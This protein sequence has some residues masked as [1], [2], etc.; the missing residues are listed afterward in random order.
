MRTAFSAA[1]L[2]LLIAAWGLTAPQPAAD[3]SVR[4]T[5]LDAATN[6]PVAGVIRVRNAAGESLSLDA[7]LPRGRG[8]PEK[9]AIHDWHVFTE[10]TV[11]RLPR[12]QFTITAFSGLETEIAA[13]PLDLRNRDRADVTLRLR[14][15]HDAHAA[16][17]WNAN[18]HVHLQKLD[19]GESDRYLVDIGMADGLDLVFVSYLERAEADVDYI[20][21]KYSRA[22]L[23]A[24][25]NAHVHFDHGEEHRHNFTGYEEGYGHVMLLAIPELIYPVSIGPGISKTGTDG[26]PLKRGIERARELGGTV[27]WCHNQ[28]GLE[29][30]PNWLAG[31]LHANNIFDGGSHGSFEH[32]F[33]RYLNAGLKVPFST[34]TDWF[35]YDFSRVYVPSRERPSPEEWLAQ[36]AAG[37]SYITNGPLL[38]FTVE[39]R[40]IGEDVALERP[41]KV[42]V[43]GSAI[44][45]VDFRKIEILQDGAVIHTGASQPVGAAWSAEL[46]VDVDVTRP[47][48]LALRTPPPS[49]PDD[50]RFSNKAP[51]NEYGRE[52]FAHTSAT[53]VDVA[54]K[55]LFDR[56]AA[57][58]L[59]AEMQRSREFIAGRGLFADESEKRRV[60]EVYDEGIAAMKGR[61][62]N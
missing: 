7:L 55:R 38:E 28:W 11:V 56:A 27:I 62:H 60:L 46:D 43:H 29:D 58:G 61:L 20:T 32:S 45:R 48:W 31:R 19:R 50:P 44:G 57:E 12:E 52:L 36:L 8:V 13:Q 49:V 33:Y 18:T 34:G 54:G 51:L 42:R 14:R 47:C 23:H 37:R 41:G 30:I 15:F 39:G 26:L 3:C 59:L 21:N 35:I 10:P 25:N 40:G 17:W 1:F 4:I 16:G 22:D 6:Q 9:V 2:V 5:L 24:L 53:F